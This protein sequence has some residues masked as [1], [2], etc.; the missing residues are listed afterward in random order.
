VKEIDLALLTKFKDT[1]QRRKKTKRNVINSLH[2]FF[3]WMK[4]RGTIDNVPQFPIIKGRDAQ[5]RV[6]LRP[7]HQQEA[8]EKLPEEHRDII[9]FMMKTGLRHGEV[10]A[11]LVSS[12]DLSA[13]A[14]WIEQRRSGC[15]ERPGTKTRTCYLFPSMM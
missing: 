2:A 15:K 12:V 8:L 7:T 3:S 9:Q 10:V 4:S 5:R 1:L 13:R 14:V 6:A 11:V